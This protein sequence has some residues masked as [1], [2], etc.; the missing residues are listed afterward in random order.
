M[1][2]YICNDTV[3]MSQSNLSNLVDESSEKCTPQHADANDLLKSLAREIRAEIDG[4]QPSDPIHD[5]GNATLAILKVRPH[6]ALQLAK[7]HVQNRPY[8]EVRACWLRLY[9]EARLHRAAELLNNASTADE[10]DWMSPL[11]KVLDLGVIVSGATVRGELYEAIFANLEAFVGQ[12]DEATSS[13]SFTF[14]PPDPLQSEHLVPTT[15]RPSL[16]AFQVHLD[17]HTTPLL[18][19]EV[20]DDWPAMQTWQ[21]AAHLLRKTLGGRRCVPIEIGETY[22]HA[23]WRQEI[24]PFRQFMYSYLL[25]TDPEEIGYLGQHNL[26]HQIPSLAQEIQTPD[27]CFSAPPETTPA[28]RVDLP[29]VPLVD[30]PQK[31]VWLGPKGTRTPLHTDPYHNIF[32][33]VFGYK[34]VRLYPP[35]VSGSVYPRG[36]DENGINESNTSQVDL[37]FNRERS[38]NVEVLHADRFPGFVAETDYREAI[39]GPGECLYIPAGWWHYI[40][41][42]TTSYSVSFWW[43]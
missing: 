1:N 28:S 38:G 24:M 3:R 27:Y 42:L 18:L 40:E 17:R 5:C 25:P 21:D 41:A 39:V 12:D 13:S 32:C 9:E 4:F 31:N 2:V 6:E 23:D 20:I 34:Y 30:E 16:E 7:D 37:K 29:P 35:H 8:R 19:T 10:E 33:Q 11:V 14:C 26:F 15:R 43:N 22:T 36:V